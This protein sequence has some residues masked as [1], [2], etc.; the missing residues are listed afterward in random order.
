ME[1]IIYADLLV[2]G[3]GTAGTMAAIRAK[4]CNPDAKV[5]IFDKSDIMYSGSIASG[6]DAFNV[7]AVP[8]FSTAEE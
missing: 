2:V 3:G 4:E 7:T 5:V 6:M 1:H 8:G